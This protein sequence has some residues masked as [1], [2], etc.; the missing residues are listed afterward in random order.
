MVEVPVPVVVER[1]VSTLSSV[2]S[3]SAGNGMRQQQ[4]KTP[5]TGSSSGGS[6]EFS[7]NR[8]FSDGGEFVSR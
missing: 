6:R 4:P 3:A 8:S 1:Q 7:W 5:G 2:H